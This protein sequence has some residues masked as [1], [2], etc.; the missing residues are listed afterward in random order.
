MTSI[1]TRSALMTWGKTVPPPEL[2]YV[3]DGQMVTWAQ[4]MARRRQHQAEL[5]R[6]KRHAISQRAY[7]LRVAYFDQSLMG[8]W[9]AMMDDWRG[10]HHGIWIDRDCTRLRAPLMRCFPLLL[11]VGSEDEQWRCW[12]PEFARCFRRRDQDRQPLGVGFVWWNG[13]DLP[14][15]IKRRMS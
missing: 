5:L 8:G 7:V 13:R 4:V 2:A 11:A 9:Q 12:K 3:V 15:Q 10:R 6:Q 14:R 1:I